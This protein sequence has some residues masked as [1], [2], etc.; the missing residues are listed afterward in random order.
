MSRRQYSLS[1]L[2]I[3]EIV[4][5][6]LGMLIGIGMVSF[7]KADCPQEDSCTAEYYDHEWHIREV[8]P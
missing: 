1:T 7:F 4:F 8:M 3:G 5:L 6:L 2:I